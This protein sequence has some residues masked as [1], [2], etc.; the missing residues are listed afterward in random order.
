MRDF[1]EAM[2]MVNMFI[3]PVITVL[4]ALP[5]VIYI[6]ARWRA[7]RDN[8]V[9]DPHLGF[10]VALSF[11]KIA[12]YQLCLLGLFLLVYGLMTDL[13]DEAQEMMLRLAGGFIVPGLIV[14]A[15][16]FVALTRTNAMELPAVSRMF[17]G[18]NLLQTGLIGNLALVMGFVMLFQEGDSGEGGRIAWSL[19]I[20]YTVAWVVQG[21]LFAREVTMGAPPPAVAQ[22][23]QRTP[24]PAAPYPPPGSPPPPSTP[25]P[26]Y[27]PQPY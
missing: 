13:G 12:S 4:V 18:L 15:A 9:A 16:H 3:S 6:V 17:A 21:L 19:V 26:G 22:F 8:Q 11:F 2:W 1:Q 5:V 20:V 14:Y 10:K 23:A 27:P 7:Y 25:P 24:P